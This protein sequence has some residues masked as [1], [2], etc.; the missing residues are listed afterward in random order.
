MIDYE[1][2]KTGILASTSRQSA[3][4]FNFYG[5]E[6]YHVNEVYLNVKNPL[7]LDA[8]MGD[9]DYVKVPDNIKWLKN[10]EVKG[11]VLYNIIAEQAFRRGY[12]G[13]I[14][15]NVFDGKETTD[16]VI[17][18]SLY[19]AKLTSNENPTSRKEVNFSLSSKPKTDN[20]QVE[21]TETETKQTGIDT[22]KTID[23]IVEEVS[24]QMIKLIK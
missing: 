20:A 18:K 4:R 17:F 15:Q 2:F 23:V 13:V 6:N 16:V 10:E 14:L 3:K 12:D 19:Q 22:D 11:K 21:K 5:E 8:N 7:Y 1:L 9:Y 24:K